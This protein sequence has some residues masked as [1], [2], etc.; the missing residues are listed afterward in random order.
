MPALRLRDVACERPR[1]VFVGINP[2]QTSGRVGHHFAGAGNPFWRLLHASG[3]TPVLLAPDEDHRLAEFGYALTNLAPRTTRTAAELSRAELARGAKELRMK[4]RAWR[5]EL[6][7]LV[8]ITLYSQIFGPSAKT[9]GP[10][11]KPELLEDVPVFVVPNP[12]GLNAA[13]PGFA[14]K[15]EWFEKLREAAEATAIP[16]RNRRAAPRR[17]RPAAEE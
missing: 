14:D 10:G 4:L 7:A 12:S 13:F 17:R 2:G 15:L 11:A 16:R 3:L 6:V 1:I 9:K 5:P 8:G